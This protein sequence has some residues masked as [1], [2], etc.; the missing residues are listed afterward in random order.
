MEGSE[1][2]IVYEGS[3][4]EI[5]YESKRVARSGMPTINP[6]ETKSIIEAEG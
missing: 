5:V 1:T 4:T 6:P 2:E 3:E